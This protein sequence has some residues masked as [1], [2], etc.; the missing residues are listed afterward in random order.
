[1]LG[2]S[3]AIPEE[4]RVACAQIFQDVAMLHHKWSSYLELFSEP[5]STSVLS[6]VAQAFFQAIEESL[7]NDI[8]MAICRLSD[9]SLTLSNENLSF[10]TLVAKCGEIPTLDPLLTAFQSAAGSVRLYRNRRVGHNDLNVRIRPHEDPLPGI[11]RLQIDEILRFAR[12]IMKAIYGHYGET[13][14][15]IQPIHHGGARDLIFWLKTAWELRDRVHEP[16]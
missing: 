8:V 3:E 15:A 12:E 14:H 13:D 11:D 16:G 10:A 6:N 1:M 4:I 9:P 7:R 5:E 2:C